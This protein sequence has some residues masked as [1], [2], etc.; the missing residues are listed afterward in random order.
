M[1]EL[2]LQLRAYGSVLD[3]ARPSVVETVDAAPL[4]ARRS[5]IVAA[6]AAFVVAIAASA[7]VFGATRSGDS[8]RPKIVTP[9]PTASITSTPAPASKSGAVLAIGDSVMEGAKGTLAAAIPGITVDAAPSRQFDDAIRILARDESVG[10]PPVT[11]VVA[12]G[13]NG[14]VTSEEIDAFMRAAG[15]LEVYFVTVRV[16][17]LW[18]SEVNVT[19]LAAPKRWPNAHIIDWHDYANAHDDWFVRDGLHLNASGQQGYAGLIA[20]T[21]VVQRVH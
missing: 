15:E 4:R 12:L 21:L 13:T 11:V 1:R 8:H 7:I 3:A 14:R 18:E 16:P 20:S 10:A 17:R 5:V 6:A 19:L 2:E 9:A